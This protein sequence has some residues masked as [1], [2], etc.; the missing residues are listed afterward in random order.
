MWDSG[1][2]RGEVLRQV[3]GGIKSGGG[4][5]DHV[6]W[7]MHAMW[8]TV[9]SGRGIL[10]AVWSTADSIGGA[11]YREGWGITVPSVWGRA[12]G[13]DEVLSV[14]RSCTC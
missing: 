5:G 3:W 13:V 11:T 7:A 2:G 9:S 6:P 12:G 1:C 14:L 4:A 10:Y 8:I